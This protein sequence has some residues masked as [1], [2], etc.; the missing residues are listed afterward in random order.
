[1]GSP[2]LAAPLTS[3]EAEGSVSAAQMREFWG[4]ATHGDAV[5]LAMA[6]LDSLIP[7]FT[8]TAPLTVGAVG[9]G[10]LLTAL[11]VAS[12]CTAPVSI[13]FAADPDVLANRASARL[14]ALC[15]RPPA[16]RFSCAGSAE[17]ANTLWSSDLEVITL[18]CKAIAHGNQSYP[19]GVAAFLHCVYATMAGAA[20]REPRAILFETSDGLWSLPREKAAV[21]SI[22]LT[23]CPRHAWSSIVICPS[24]H[25]GFPMRRSR[26]FYLGVLRC[27]TA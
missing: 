5:R 18:P 6:T 25:C 14:L 13:V 24:V 8:S 17:M 20:I 27:P 12:A 16:T 21:E 26:V 15:G 19:E 1:M 3:L 11:Q 10:L 2:E 22:L 4:Q 23:A 7:G 9:S